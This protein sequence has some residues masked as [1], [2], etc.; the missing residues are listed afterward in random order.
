ML[1]ISA[2]R[3]SV[4]RR[5]ACMIAVHRVISGELQYHVLRNEEILFEKTGNAL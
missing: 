4:R 1:K 2:G 5:Y 3:W